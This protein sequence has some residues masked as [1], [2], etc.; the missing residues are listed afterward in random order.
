MAYAFF[1][2]GSLTES[3]TTTATS[4][5]TLTLTLSS[6]KY[7]VF[8][9]SSS[10]TM[11]LPDATT[12]ILN[13]AFEVVNSSTGTITVQNNGS[14]T[15]STVSA[16]TSMV[17]RVTDISTSNGSFDAT[18]SSSGGSGGLSANEAGQFT[19][20]AA[21]GFTSKSRTLKFNP[22]EISGNYWTTKGS[23]TSNHVGGGAASLNGL[24]YS[25][26]GA[27]T[28]AL[29][30]ILTV[31]DR[32]NDDT[33]FWAAST[34][35]T[36]G[37]IESNAYSLNGFVYFV[38]LSLHYQFNDATSAWASKTALAQSEQSG[39][40]WSNNGYGYFSHG[41]PGPTT[42]TQLYNDVAN[43]WTLRASALTAMQEPAFFVLNSKAYVFTGT[44][45]S[46]SNIN[47]IYNDQ[48]NSWASG[49][50][51][52][53]S[54]DS[55]RGFLGSG[56]GYGAGGRTTGGGTHAEVYQYSDSATSW[57]QRASIATDRAYLAA[58]DLNGAGLVFNGEQN[59]STALTSVQGY[60]ASSF[61]SLGSLLRS[62]A[63]PTSIATAVILNAVSPTVPVQVRTDGDNWKNLVNGGTTLKLNE[64]IADKF[65]QHGPGTVMGGDNGGGSITSTETFNYTQNVWVTRTAL[66]SA[67]SRNAGFKAGG[68][69]FSAGGANASAVNVATNIRFDD[70]TNTYATK[71]SMT[72][73]A[74]ALAMPFSIKNIGYVVGSYQGS[75]STD[76]QQYNAATD[77][78]A[79]KTVLP[80]GRRG[81]YSW[82]LGE[83]GYVVGGDTVGSGSSTAIG[84]YYSPDLN[85]WTSITSMPAAREFGSTGVSMGGYG[86]VHN[87]DSGTNINYR[88]DPVTTTWATKTAVPSQMKFSAEF[89]TN[90]VLIVAGGNN[91]SQISTVREY[92]IYSDVWA[93]KTSLST[94]RYF[95]SPA[96]AG[97]YRNYELRASI[98]GYFAGL[99]GLV[100]TAMPNLAISR[101]ANV[102]GFIGGQN[103]TVGGDSGGAGDAQAQILNKATGV[104]SLYTS[105]PVTVGGGA[106]F[107]LGGQ[108]YVIVPSTSTY[109]LDIVTGVYTTRG[110]LGTSRSSRLSQTSAATL[111]G[112]GYVLGGD[113]SNVEQYSMSSNSWTSKSGTTN[114][115]TQYTNTVV[116][117]G[118]WINFAGISGGTR[119]NGV[120]L[121][122]DMSNAWTTKSNYPVSIGGGG[123]F[124]YNGAGYTFSGSLGA[125]GSNNTPNVYRYNAN[126]DIWTSMQAFPLNNSFMGST[127]DRFVIGGQ[128]GSTLSATYQFVDSVKQAVVSAGISV[129]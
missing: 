110:S 48:I 85:T 9:G 34:A 58:I 87:D 81:G 50:V 114:G 71:A 27:N 63:V 113:S 126:S 109:S 67:I 96:C 107:V 77:T 76:N 72:G 95:V 16:G 4:G 14:V 35:V 123:S 93:T 44:T 5:G 21:G 54:Y 18:T 68:F 88:Y 64:V 8:T 61:Y 41:T 70:V 20:L 42:V 125:G 3:V 53:L 75:V 39:A 119:S 73:V 69:G 117:E 79:L 7:Q 83:L 51:Y 32:Y 94:A 122:N 78:W 116:S 65:N 62:T 100:W 38:G 23:T 92:N 1:K 19:A 129:S 12:M 6:D 47:Q 98:P 106:G 55:M 112:F 84:H 46:P 101:E 128:N 66:A 104:W 33:N 15:V 97:P 108:L 10:H 120:Y 28:A 31:N 24:A 37:L 25:I 56:F 43:T 121:Y 11:R 40:S 45:G 91:G 30:T 60:T 49:T 111:N 103:V 80:T 17:F 52:P 59:N 74:A 89:R 22:E 57:L 127:S 105:A 102:S 86:W 115:F 36:T 82:D 13:Q 99:G 2:N 118:F 90:D 124:S 29:G 26:S